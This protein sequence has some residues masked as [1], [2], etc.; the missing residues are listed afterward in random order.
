MTH[1]T[2]A[3]GLRQ[4][5]RVGWREERREIQEGEEIYIYTHTHTHTYTYN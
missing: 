3:R 2:Q 5:R 1:G 4:P